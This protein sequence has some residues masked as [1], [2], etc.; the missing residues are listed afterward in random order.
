MKDFIAYCGLDCETCEARLATVN[1]DDA[2]RRKVAALWSELNQVEITPAMIHCVGCRIDGVKTPYCEKLS[3]NAFYYCMSDPPVRTA[4]PRGD[5]W[6]LRR[7][8]ELRK[9]GCDRQE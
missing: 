4:A 8:G 5:L 2:L 7:D 3:S 9:A 6:Q 1:D